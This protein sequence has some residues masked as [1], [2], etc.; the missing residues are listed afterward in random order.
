MSRPFLLRAAGGRVALRFERR[1]LAVLLV[2]AAALALAMFAAL[3][4]GSRTTPWGAV[5]AA[6]VAPEQSD[7]AFIVNAVRM[8][9][10]AL[11]VLVGAA[12]A[13]AGLILQGVVRNPLASPDVV[14]ITGGASVAAVLYLSLTAG[15]TDWLPLAALAGATV[16]AVAVFT[17]AWRRG[18][19]PLRFVLVGVGVASAAGAVT[20]LLIVLNRDVTSM[21]AYLWLVGSLYAAQWGDVQ[22][23]LPW[24]L[25]LLPLTLLYARHMDAMALGDVPATGLGV[26]VDTSRVALLVASVTLAG[27][28][29]AYAGGLA[30]VGLIAPHIARRVIRSGF[31]GLV[32]GSAIIGALIVLA[33]DTLGRVAF[34]PHDLPAG[35]FVSGIGAGFFVYLLYRL[36]R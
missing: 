34:L 22:G 15:D 30:F 2:L 18:L 21:Q 16:A 12:L 26:D 6:V 33:A 19:A 11:A 3:S 25:A 36:R 1:T 31:A 9:R 24:L 27:A 23:L 28:A 7:L 10:V 17:L 13:V 14:G 20:T 35:L 8:P 4:V 29:V 5:L 32:W